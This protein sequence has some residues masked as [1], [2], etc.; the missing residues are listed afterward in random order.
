M[1]RILYNNQKLPTEILTSIF[2]FLE[3]ND[4]NECKRVCKFWYHPAN[5]RFYN[6]IVI[7]KQ[8]DYNFLVEHLN[9]FGHLVQH[10]HFD[11]PRMVNGTEI[12]AKQKSMFRIFRRCANV[13]HI[14]SNDDT[15][16]VVLKAL[17]ILRHVLDFKKLAII[18]RNTTEGSH[19]YRECIKTYYQ[20]I[21]EFYSASLLNHLNGDTRNPIKLPNLRTLILKERITSMNNIAAVLELYTG[22]TCLSLEI[23]SLRDLQTVG[24][25]KIPKYTTLKSLT[26][27]IPV[28]YAF[29]FGDLNRLLLHLPQLESLTIYINNTSTKLLTSL[30]NMNALSSAIKLFR[31]LQEAKIISRYGDMLQET[32]TEAIDLVYLSY[33]CNLM[34][35]PQLCSS[36]DWTTDIS[37]L[38]DSNS[39][40]GHN[41]L[42]DAI[43]YSFS[44][45]SKQQCVQIRALPTFSRDYQIN[46]YV[47]NFAAT[48]TSLHIDFQTDLA[49]TNYVGYL[50]PLLQAFKKMKKLTIVGGQY[51]VPSQGQ[52]CNPNVRELCVKNFDFSAA[53]S[54]MDICSVFPGLEKLSL[55]FN[56]HCAS[57]PN[58]KLIYMPDTNIK[59]V[60]IDIF[61]QTEELLPGI[62]TFNNQETKQLTYNVSLRLFADNLISTGQYLYQSL[63]VPWDTKYVTTFCG[64]SVLTMSLVGQK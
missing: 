58:R 44:K 21:T 32:F 63:A 29:F 42:R 27:T 23:L 47:Q 55:Q 36:P 33:I 12:V 20:S 59:E 4:M 49:F 26:I 35:E 16:D 18:P 52:F 24:P 38:V 30:S 13:E 5:T 19:F 14:S 50:I 8:V 64:D 11:L 25:V 48:A 17:F 2:N 61:D 40:Q 62:T 22:L 53:F 28:D 57:M 3:T 45:K 41:V 31:S 56:I 37:F 7:G 1:A 51:N 46:R 10:I 39:L 15:A 34:I 9:V 6:K 54:A 60:C 43:T